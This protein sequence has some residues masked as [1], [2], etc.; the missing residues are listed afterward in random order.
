[1]LDPR[2]TDA[3]E[4]YRVVEE[5]SQL[6]KICLCIT[7]RISTVPPDCKC[8]EIPTL[9]KGATCDA[10]HRIY[11]HDERSG[12]IDNIL[13]QLDLHLLSFTLLATV[14]HNSKW[15]ADRLTREWDERRTDILQ[16][17]HDK[18]LAATIE[19]SRGLRKQH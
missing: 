1:M 2:G 13:E 19:P 17:E 7:S 11:Q 5:L 4:I 16:A 12:L 14:A 15:N 18:S 3:E 6:G 9:S 10:F 8:L